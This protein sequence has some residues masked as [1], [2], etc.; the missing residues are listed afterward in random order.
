VP[1]VRKAAG[2]KLQMIWEESV[3]APAR[4][5]AGEPRSGTSQAAGPLGF[6]PGEAHVAFTRRAWRVHASSAASGW[7]NLFVSSQTE[8]PE[9]ADYGNSRHHLLVVHCNGPASVSLR[10][11]GRTT[12]KKIAAGGSAFVPAGEGFTVR[13][14]DTVD[15]AHVYLHRDL[16]GRIADERGSAIKA[17]QM[18]PFFGVQDP[19]LEH[20]ALSCVAALDQPSK[21]ASLY[22]DH[23]AWAMAAHLIEIQE[24]VSLTPSPAS[25]SGLADRQ[26]R[27]VREYMLER[28][29]GH[30][31]VEELAAVAGLSP[32]YFARQFKL[33]IGCSPHRY[34][35]SLRVK[36][37]KELLGYDYMSI[38]EIA[39]NCGLCHQEHMTRVF[40]AQCGTTPAAFRRRIQ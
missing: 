25:R 5:R 19:L 18:Q 35:R 1:I 4:L 32:V 9:E 12:V 15:S 20:L 21:T 11:A 14:F 16:I 7:R 28:M 39:L 27:R 2:D 24:R 38:A 34:L 23:L 36:R 30:L 10:M 3:S 31:G 29:H 22:V 17:P 8:I 37:A 26:L 6:G 13:I 33:R 40:R